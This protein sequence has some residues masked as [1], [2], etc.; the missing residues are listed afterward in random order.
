MK[1]SKVTAKIPLGLLEVLK[2]EAKRTGIGVQNIAGQLL[3][4]GYNDIREKQRAA[5]EEQVAAAPEEAAD[6]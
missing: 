5:Q 4:H 1:M 6:E 2:V 3:T